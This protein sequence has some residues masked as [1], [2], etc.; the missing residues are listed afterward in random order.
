MPW[1]TLI[2][3]L[4]IGS[5]LVGIGV[6]AVLTA[7]YGTLMPIL[8]AALAGFIIAIPVSILVSRALKG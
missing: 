5:T 1:L 4:F 8:W 2:L 6:I 7:G 3:H